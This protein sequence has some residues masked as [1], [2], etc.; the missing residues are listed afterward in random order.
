MIVIAGLLAFFSVRTLQLSAR[1]VGGFFKSPLKPLALVPV[2]MAG[3]VILELANVEILRLR[4][5]L[6]MSALLATLAGLYYFEKYA[7]A[8]EGLVRRQGETIASLWVGHDLRDPLQVVAN[9]VFILRNR[10]KSA[11]SR[12]AACAVCINQVREEVNTIDAQ[13]RYMNK[14]ASDLRDYGSQVQVEPVEADLKQLITDAASSVAI[15]DSVRTSVRIDEN[16]SKLMVD[17]PAIE[18]A[19]AN[20]IRN[21]VE[22]MPSGG[23]LTTRAARTDDSVAVSFGDTG[24]GIA[25][26]N[27][28]M[29]FRPFFTT[30]ARGQGLGLPVCRKLIEAHG[31]SI[32]VESVARKGT[33]FIVTIPLRPNPS[34]SPKP[35]AW[36]IL[37][38]PIS[39]FGP[40]ADIG[41]LFSIFRWPREHTSPPHAELSHVA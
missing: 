16:A 37:R 41:N 15:P 14:I 23:Q 7:S 1:F 24:I 9:S 2:F 8:R 39:S 4:S 17:P 30:K 6:S 32:Q 10:F 34:R 18:R 27:M 3:V 11:P 33:T 31:G 22:A 12:V 38:G 40:G 13:L 5:L 36:L 20:M 29:L 21:A 26:E 28:N 35:T 19:F 25:E